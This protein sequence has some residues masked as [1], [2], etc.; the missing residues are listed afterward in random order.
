MDQ[1]VT[2][3]GTD[4]NITKESIAP[5]TK[6]KHKPTPFFPTPNLSKLLDL[7]YKISSLQKNAT[8]W[9]MERNMPLKGCRKVQNMKNFIGQGPHVLQ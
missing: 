3:E 2:L 6:K 8:G 5:L 9:G 4:L 7:V 1:A